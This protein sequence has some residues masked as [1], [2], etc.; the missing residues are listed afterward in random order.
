MLKNFR[1]ISKIIIIQN[2]QPF[3]RQIGNLNDAAA[4]KAVYFIVAGRIAG[5]AD[6]HIFRQ[7]SEVVDNKNGA[8]RRNK[9]RSV[10]DKVKIF[11]IAKKTVP[12][13]LQF[14]NSVTSVNFILCA[15][16]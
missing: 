10:Q 12:E 16:S 8:V 1:Q 15:F 13:T 9:N 7:F 2:N 5:Q 11:V 3:G 14:R 4:V 6:I